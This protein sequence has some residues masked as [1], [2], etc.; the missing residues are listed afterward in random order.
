MKS[1]EDDYGNKINDYDVSYLIK[2]LNYLMTIEFPK[3]QRVTEYLNKIATLCN[4]LGIPIS[5][6]L[7]IGLS[8]TQHYLSVGSI[9]I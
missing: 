7:P 9:R 4:K 3:I 6:T 1:I 8:V 5:W 2:S